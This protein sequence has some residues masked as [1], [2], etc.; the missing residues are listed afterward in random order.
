LN[1]PAAARIPI[2][3]T[4]PL[5]WLLVWLAVVL[6]PIDVA[7]RRLTTNPF[8]LASAVRGERAGRRRAREEDATTTGLSGLV[9]GVEQARRARTLKP[10]EQDEQEQDESGG[11]PVEP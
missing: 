9:T 10:E 11:V 7:L 3:V 8:K 6:W 4:S 1:T 2:K 5:F